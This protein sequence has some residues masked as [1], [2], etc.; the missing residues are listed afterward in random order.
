MRKLYYNTGKN[1]IE[2]FSAVPPT[3]LKE[4]LDVA[5][6]HVLLVLLHGALCLIKRGEHNVRLPARSPVLVEAKRHVGRV[7]HRAKPLRDLV[8]SHPEVNFEIPCREV[9]DD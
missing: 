6:L 1:T 5:V 8:L 4:E 2:M 9:N 7:G 3:L